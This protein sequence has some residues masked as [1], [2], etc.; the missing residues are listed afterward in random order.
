MFEHHEAPARDGRRGEQPW[1]DAPW[2][3]EQCGEEPGSDGAADG[4]LEGAP[5]GWLRTPSADEI[6]ST[7]TGP[8]LVDVVVLADPAALDEYA[9]V[10]LVAAW[11]RLT[12]WTQARAAEVAVELARRGRVTVAPRPT[13]GD[14]SAPIR[15]GEARRGAAL[16]AVPP[17]TSWRCG[18]ASR[19]KPRNASSTSGGLWPVR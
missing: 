2:A 5:P 1:A 15:H 3:E 9:L 10:E 19:G 7:P 11:A 8:P 16:R 4:A 17:P 18:C 14:A 12:A 6:E 13:V